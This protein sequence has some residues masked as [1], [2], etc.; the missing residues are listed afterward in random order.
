MSWF[1][2]LNMNNKSVRVNFRS[3]LAV[4]KFVSGTPGEKSNPCGL[5]DTI[6]YDEGVENHSK[7]QN[8]SD[9]TKIDE[10]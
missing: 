2:N 3:A 4:G 6:F 9:L 8:N 7:Q 10:L 5:L 1:K